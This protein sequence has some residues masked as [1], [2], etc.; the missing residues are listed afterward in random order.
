MDRTK[1]ENF[2]KENGR[3]SI[4]ETQSRFS[5]KYKEARDLFTELVNNNFIRPDGELYFAYTAPPKKISDK[6]EGGDSVVEKLKEAWD[7]LNPLHKEAVEYCI[8]NEY[9]NSNN[10]RKALRTG[11]LDASELIEWLKK[12]GAVVY[13]ERRSSYK[14]LINR[15]EMLPFIR[16]REEGLDDDESSIGRNDET[17]FLDFDF[18]SFFP[19]FLDDDYDDDDD[20]DERDDDGEEESDDDEHESD[21]I[22][23]GDKNGYAVIVLASEFEDS[24]DESGIKRRELLMKEVEKPFDIITKELNKVASKI[25]IGIPEERANETA[26]KLLPMKIMAIAAPILKNGE[27]VDEYFESEEVCKYVGNDIIRWIAS[28]DDTPTKSAAIR[29][30][31]KLCSR[32]LF[33]VG[34]Y[35]DRLIN[36]ARRSLEKM[37]A[38]DY[39]ALRKSLRNE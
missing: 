14:V 18:H 10:L 4:P 21:A 12:I 1:I 26:Q 28:L 13:D 11:Y 32:I 24:C 31:Q 16:E 17:E 20:D 19:D 3:V 25:R 7:G 36:K 30:I 38:A 15:D 6:T 35:L 34:Y 22:Q 39:K 33:S 37:P 23:D 2:I 5:L 8:G 9:I 29:K 27:I